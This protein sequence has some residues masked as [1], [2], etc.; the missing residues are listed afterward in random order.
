M[1]LELAIVEACDPRG[2]RVRPVGGKDSLTVR[3][4]ARVQNRIRIRCGDLVAVDLAPAQPELVWRWWRVEVLPPLGDALGPNQVIVG[5]RGVAAVARVGR[6]AL[7][8]E[9]GDR[10][11]IMK[12]EEEV[13]IL[14]RELDG[15]PEAPDWVRHHYLPLVARACAGMASG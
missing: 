8:L 14:D 3:Y 4:S 12:T 10:A 6:P 2:C 11:W 9:P 15:Q 7:S 13:V 1:N 5:D